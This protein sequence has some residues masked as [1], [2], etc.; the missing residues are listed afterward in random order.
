MSWFGIAKALAEYLQQIIIEE[1][2]QMGIEEGLA[3]MEG[4]I[5]NPGQQA[6]YEV[7]IMEAYPI[8][9]EQ[10]LIMERADHLKLEDIEMPHK[11]AVEIILQAG[12]DIVNDYY[13]AAQDPFLILDYI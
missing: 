6:I 7:Y 8:A 3:V 12:I 1:F 9:A 11:Q 4:M 5:G 13:Q 10:K 2:V